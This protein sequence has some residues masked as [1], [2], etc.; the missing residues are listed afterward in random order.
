MALRAEINLATLLE[1]CYQNL[2]SV[3]QNSDS[4]VLAKGSFT[5][6]DV[7]WWSGG[8]LPADHH[9]RREISLGPPVVR[10]TFARTSAGPLSDVRQ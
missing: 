2:Y 9:K 5:L 8:Y 10:R 3:I 1:I 7:R 6:A 4:E